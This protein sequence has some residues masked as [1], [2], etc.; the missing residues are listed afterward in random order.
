MGLEVDV[1]PRA[2][3][4]VS[5]ASRSTNQ[6]DSNALVTVLSVDDR[7]QHEGV[8]PAVPGDVDE[9]DQSAGVERLHPGQA[10]CFEPLAPR[11]YLELVG[12]EGGLVQLREL[13]IVDTRAQKIG[14]ASGHVLIMVPSWPLVDRISR[15]NG[16]RDI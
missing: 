9:P 12:L 16:A 14:K 11:Q 15:P 4:L 7:V 1:K 8:S 6:L 5:C 2:A 13:D 3:R 10:V